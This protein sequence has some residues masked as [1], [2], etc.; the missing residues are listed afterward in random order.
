MLQLF[1]SFASCN[2]SLTFVADGT[3]AWIFQGAV[4]EVT[5]THTGQRVSFLSI[6]QL[7]QDPRAS[8]VCVKEYKCQGHIWLLI[9]CNRTVQQG[10]IC[11]LNVGSSM[12]VKTVEVPQQ[13]RK[14][15]RI[16]FF[17][18]S[19]M[20]NNTLITL[21]HTLLCHFTMSADYSVV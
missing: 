19:L 15:Y 6:S 2:E 20:Q 8:I 17:P 12:V 3:I 11:L 18:P 16:A 5:S 1:I 14:E 9:A 4:L 21:L 10:L 7:L 13:V